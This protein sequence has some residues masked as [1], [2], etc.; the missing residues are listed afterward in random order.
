MAPTA[1]AGGS[2][3]GRCSAL[4]AALPWL[5]LVAH[6][7]HTGQAGSGVRL[8][9]VGRTRLGMAMALFFGLQ[10]LQAYAVFGWFATLWR[11]NGYSPTTAGILLG[12]VAA[13]SIPLSLWL[14]AAAARAEDQ[15]KIL[16]AVMAC[17]PLG[18]VGLL[19]A[20]HS[21]A[22][23]CALLV[24]VGATHVPADPH[25]DRAA[26]A[27]PRRH[28]GP[29]GVHAVRG[30]PDGRG[31]PVRGR[32]PL[33]EHRRLDLAAGP[34]AG[35]DRPADP[36]RPLRR[37]PDVHRGPAHLPPARRPL[38]GELAR[39]ECRSCAPRCRLCSPKCAF[40]RAEVSRSCDTEPC[41]FSPQPTLV[42]QAPQL[43]HEQRHGTSARKNSRLGGRELARRRRQA[44]WVRGRSR[45]PSRRRRRSSR[46]TRW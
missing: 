4:L 33:R 25:H 32:R 37:P 34:P 17:Y 38:A 41:R 28:R 44:S 18:Y 12:L 22:V 8:L 26:L 7:Q 36:A 10:S 30:L 11:D 29:L 23:P 35:A 31:R 3:R 13:V 40:L 24:G 19:V 9:D 39:R 16:T 5:R 43:A 45:R 46:R 2:A 14:P 42:G 15:R 27:H 20:P 6:D 21:L 1:G